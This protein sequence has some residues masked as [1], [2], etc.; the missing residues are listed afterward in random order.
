MKCKI[1]RKEVA[2]TGNS[3]C[4]SGSQSCRIGM[5]LRLTELR[6]RHANKKEI[7]GNATGLAQHTGPVQNSNSQ[8][9]DLPFSHSVRKFNDSTPIHSC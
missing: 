8:F 4:G 3:F 1:N 2:K 9:M 5:G 6:D 7:S